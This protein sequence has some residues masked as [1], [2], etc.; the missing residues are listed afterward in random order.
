[1]QKTAVRKIRKWVLMILATA[2]A[3]TGILVGTAYLLIIKPLHKDALVGEADRRSII[4][5]ATPDFR[6]GTNGTFTIAQV[7]DTHLYNGSGKTD[8]HTLENLKKKLQEL[9]PD[10][11]VASGDILDGYNP[12][13]RVNLQE[14]ADQFASVMEDLG[15]Y[16]A[17]IPGNNDG[18]YLNSA[19]DAA[20]YFSK[21][22]HCIVANEENLTGATHYSVD[23]KD[24]DGETVHSLVFVDSLAR[25]AQNNYDYI[26][27]DQV[28]WL[29]KTLAAKKS[30]APDAKV[31][32]FFHMNTPAMVDA[33]RD[34][35]AYQE[36][37]APIPES[38]RNNI[39]KN[40]AAD[41]AIVEAGNVGLVAIGHIHP[42]ENWC[43]FYN[44]LYY[45]IARPSGYEVSDEPGVTLIIVDT[46]QQD[47]R[48]MYTFT[49]NLYPVD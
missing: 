29:A 46:R 9:K 31:S 40:A 16:W 48:Q 24:A 43:S 22:A 37:Y 11:V 36:G 1:M 4:D 41:A 28:Q 35:N 15:L 10:F 32:V 34:G 2:V 49:D 27:D 7:T 14:A 17:Y 30:A 21:Y 6:V 44:N 23:W 47:V 18:E 8:T 12:Y 33:A 25:D 5:S 42:N 26:H 3:I 20:A 39:S 19:R 45:H 38:L 13:F